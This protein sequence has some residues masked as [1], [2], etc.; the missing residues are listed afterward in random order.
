[1]MLPP[2]SCCLANALLAALRGGLLLAQT[3]R[4][5]EPLRDSLRAAVAH[6]E[7]FAATPG[8]PGD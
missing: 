7:T 1:M 4:R 3:L 2:P 6:L 8:G 5:A